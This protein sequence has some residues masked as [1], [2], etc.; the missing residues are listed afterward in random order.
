MRHTSCDLFSNK[1]L[2]LDFIPAIQKGIFKLRI[3]L[4][5]MPRRDSYDIKSDR[6]ADLALHK[7]V[8]STYR[9]TLSVSGYHDD[10]LHP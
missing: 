3:G 6:M 4:P 8:V 1:L 7:D 9:L 5:M 2:L 10:F